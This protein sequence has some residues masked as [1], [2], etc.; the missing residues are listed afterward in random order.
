[1]IGHPQGCSLSPILLCIFVSDM[2]DFLAHSG[3]LLGGAA[4]K[5]LM[6][7]DDLALLAE[8]AEDLQIA[9]NCLSTY[10][11]ENGLNINVEKTKVLIFHKGRLPTCQF[12]LNNA[13][14]E[15]VNEFTYL[16]FA[17]TSQLS[18]TS[19][20]DILNTK[21]SSKCGF[22]L[23]KLKPCNVPIDI[24][25]DLFNCYVLPTY[26]YGLAVWLGK[27]SQSSV[28]AMNAVFTKFL[29][30]YL[31][32]PFHASNSICHYITE[33]QPLNV[34]LE[35]LLPASFSSLNFPEILHGLKL[36]L[37]DNNYPESSYDPVPLV[38]T[39]FWRSKTYFKIPMY[40]H[41][42]CW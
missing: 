33:T 32:L 9:I 35:S 40:A 8:T 38:P 28:A 14:L 10:C 24:V 2:P 31:C 30:R 17:F 19:H 6:F 18:F 27:C 20:L 12:T 23:S 21:A 16:G 41:R 3:V 36:T 7:A 26:R 37:N 5:Y 4:L 1:M 15:I 25:L 22:L 11:K 29:K 42:D 34:T 39:F 13:P